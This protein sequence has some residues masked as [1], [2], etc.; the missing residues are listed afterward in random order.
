MVVPWPQCETT[1]DASWRRTLWGAERTTAT[2]GA[3][4]RAGSSIWP[5]ATTART[6]MPEG[7]DH[8]LHQ[9]SLVLVHVLKPTSTSGFVLSSGH[10]DDHGSVQAGSSR[11]GPT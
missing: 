10:G 5:S 8:A 2:L 4:E 9:G 7:V 3:D 11:T 6:S 1:T